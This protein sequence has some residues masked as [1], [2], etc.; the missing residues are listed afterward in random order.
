[1]TTTLYL[2]LAVLVGVGAATQS[3]LLAAMGR[4][5]GPYEG[6]WINML[7]AIG[8]L[9]AL[10]VVREFSG[11]SPDLPAPFRN[12]A[13]FALVVLMVGG[14]LAISVRGLDPIY[15]ITGLFAIAYL[16]G[17]GYGAPRV[18]I[19]LFVA[20]VTL[21]QLAG[22]LAFDHAGAFG[23]DVRH[24]SVAR[25]GGLAAVLAGVLIVRFAP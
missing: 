11:R 24:V 15:A 12:G 19:A 10:F 4:D 3:A 20:G 16:L 25:I 6:T 7:A 13:V 8:G 5:K 1:M 23:L 22:A 18:G 2:C 14:A 17:I 9:S 21:G